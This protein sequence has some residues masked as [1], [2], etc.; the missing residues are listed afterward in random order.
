MYHYSIYVLSLLWALE[1]YIPFMSD[2]EIMHILLCGE[3]PDAL[4]VWGWE[5]RKSVRDARLARA[6]RDAQTRQKK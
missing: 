2:D 1:E 3:E 5:V 4:T 6:F